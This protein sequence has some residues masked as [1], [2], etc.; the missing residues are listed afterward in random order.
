MWVGGDEGLG[1]ALVAGLAKIRIYLKSF[2]H[3]NNLCLMMFMLGSVH[4][5]YLVV[6]SHIASLKKFI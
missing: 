6:V 3:S 5:L 1:D 2:V 4:D